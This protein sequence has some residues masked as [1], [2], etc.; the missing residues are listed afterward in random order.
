MFYRLLPDVPHIA[1]I[2]DEEYNALN[3]DQQDKWKHEDNLRLDTQMH[4]LYAKMGHSDKTVIL[5]SL[6][7]EQKNYSLD[8]LLKPIGWDNTTEK[9]LSLAQYM[10]ADKGRKMD[11]EENARIT[12]VLDKSGHTGPE[13]NEMRYLLETFIRTMPVNWHKNGQDWHNDPNHNNPRNYGEM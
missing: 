9:P 12:L 3:A 6:D 4:E 7:K 1:Y 5:D 11:E 8:I 13:R 10:E 2:S